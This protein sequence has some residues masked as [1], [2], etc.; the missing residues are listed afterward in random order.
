RF[1]YFMKFWLVM[2]FITALY[3]CSQQWIGYIPRELEWIKRDPHEFGLLF[4]GGVIRKFSFL[5]GVVTFGSLCGAM[6]TI[7]L[8]LALN[9]KNRRRKWTF[10]LFAIILFLGMAYSGTRTFTIMLP[11]GL[12]L[13]ILVTIRNKTTLITMLLTFL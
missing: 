6:S 9:E 5:D 4:Q 13:Y 12:A 1:R 10:Y 2:S 8:I 11:V 7:S 3:A